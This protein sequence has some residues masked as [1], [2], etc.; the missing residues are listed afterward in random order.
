MKSKLLFLLLFNAFSV[1]ALPN[2]YSSELIDDISVSTNSDL[3]W[4]YNVYYRYPKT[5]EE[6]RRWM[7]KRVFSLLQEELDSKDSLTI[8]TYIDNFLNLEVSEVE[9]KRLNLYPILLSFYFYN[10]ENVE[11]ISD[12]DSVVIKWI[13][14]KT[15]LVYKS[16]IKDY[17]ENPRITSSSSAFQIRMYD[18]NGECIFI[19]EEELFQFKSDINRIIRTTNENSTLCSVL[20]RFKKEFGMSVV[21]SSGKV[22]REDSKFWDVLS[23]Y[24]ND[25]LQKN[26]TCDEIILPIL[27]VR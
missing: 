4:F 14:N 24:L 1:T 18:K 6:F 16:P 5:T 20:F 23:S 3:D 17:F 26:E 9:G 7:R 10:K 2:Q 21:Y 15:Q 27:F 22:T 11:L 13:E 19:S 25:Y 8:E 12:E